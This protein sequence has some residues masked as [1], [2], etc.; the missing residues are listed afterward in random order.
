MCVEKHMAIRANTIALRSSRLTLQLHMTPQISHNRPRHSSGRRSSRKAFTLIELLVVIAIIAI[1]AGMLLPA[2]ATAKA[3]ATMISC[4][5]NEKQLVLATIS[6]SSDFDDKWV[7][8]NGGDD[9]VNLANPPANYQP[10][11]WIQGR[12]GSNLGNQASADGM[13]SEKVSLLATYMGKAKASFKCPGDKSLHVYNGQKVTFPR[14]YA[15][16]TFVGWT[17][18]TETTHAGEPAGYPNSIYKVYK[19]TSEGKPAEYFIFGEVHPLSICRPQFGTHPGGTAQGLIYHVPG[20][21]HNQI[22][23]FSFGD[24]HAEV[25]KWINGLFNN[26][27]LPEGDTSWH[28]HGSAFSASANGGPAKIQTDLGWLNTHAT[29]KKN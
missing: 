2:L 8:N 7:A 12:E 20:N 4:I 25:H 28:N 27:K 5:N 19:K 13:I 21:Y 17:P 11:V 18:T 22:S 9:V 23:T 29:E 16:N 24:G 3:K 26:P 15:M 10:T 6:Y 14:S 1:L